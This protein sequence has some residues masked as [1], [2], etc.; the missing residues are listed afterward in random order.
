MELLR[1]ILSVPGNRENMLE[2]SKQLHADIIV[3]DLEDSVPHEEKARARAIVKN[4]I[5]KLMGNGS[6]IYVRINSLDGGLAQEDLGAV[7]IQ[8]IDGIS[9]PK[10]STGY[11]IQKVAEFLKRLEKERG[12][13]EGNVKI[14]PWIET[15]LGLINAYEIASASP[16]VNGVIFGANDLV[17]ETGMTRSEEGHELLY[18]R[19]KIVIA[20]RAA[21]VAAIDTPYNNFKDERG[22]IREATLARNLGF[23]GKF[24]IH[25][26][27]VDVV[28]KIFRPS[29][30]EVAYSKKVVTAFDEA[31]AKGFASA[32]L[33][34]KMIDIPIAQRAL[35]ILLTNEAISSKER[36]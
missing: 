12:L 1:T 11:D 34:G 4:W 18:P 15:S 35:I 7:I 17:L 32:S 21:G 30:E 19:T 29:E 5:P 22:L 24:V 36:H 2:K 33:D 6:R 16:R 20:A 14:L 23:R 25:P 3:L 9:Q 27:Q 31:R 13:P 8:G 28:N 26:S 10:P